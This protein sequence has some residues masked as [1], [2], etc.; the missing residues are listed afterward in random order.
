MADCEVTNSGERL[1]TPTE[2][3]HLWLITNH[4]EYIQSLQENI[5]VNLVDVDFIYVKVIHACDNLQGKLSEFD[6]SLAYT[7]C[8]ILRQHVQLSYDY[9]LALKHVD[10]SKQN[11]ILSDWYLVHVAA[12]EFLQDQSLWSQHY[13][14]LMQCFMHRC[15]SDWH[16]DQE[17]WQQN[18]Q[19]SQWIAEKIWCKFVK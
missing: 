8:D 17:F 5:L 10:V 7:W 16:L 1:H 12:R 14:C 6:A 2:C 4:K 15:N 18:S 3:D 13:N 11:Q 9:V 19:I